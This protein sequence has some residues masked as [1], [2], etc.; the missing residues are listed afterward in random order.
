MPLKKVAT[1]LYTN[2]DSFVDLNDSVLEWVKEGPKARPKGMILKTMREALYTLDKALKEGGKEFLISEEL[3]SKLNS[4][5]KDRRRTLG[6]NGFHMGRAL[7]ELGLEPL[8]SYPCRPSSIMMASPD[9]KVACDNGIKTPKEAIREGDSEYDHVIFEF[10][11]DLK[12]GIK[13]AGRHIFSWDLMSSMGIFDYDFLKR[14][15]DSRFTN[16]LIMGYAHLLLPDYKGKTDEIIDYLDKTRRPKVHF[17]LGRGSEESVRYAMKKFSDYNCSESWGMNEDECVAYL[18]AESMN[19]RDLIDA[20]IESVGVYGL[21]R[22]CVHSVD[23][24]FSVSKC[25]IKKEVEALEM[26]CEVATALTLGSIKDNLDKVKS[27]PRSDIKP[28]KRVLNGYNLCV[29]PTIFNDNPRI[30]TGLGDTFAGTQ[31]VIALG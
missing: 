7:Y 29:I 13:I 14:A 31:A 2:W 18:K 30:L 1:G 28:V 10:K 27:L 6:G 11:K 26:A 8:V 24:A 17:E 16:L 5:F 21:K 22:I 20:S 3:Y 19:L 4:I 15:T 9:F 25:D 23:F 12:E